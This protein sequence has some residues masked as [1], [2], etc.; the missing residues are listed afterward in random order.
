MV[1]TEGAT[2]VRAERP[3]AGWLILPALGTLIG[4][5]YYAWGVVQIALV[6]KQITTIRADLYIWLSAELMS[7]GLL[8]LGWAGALYL[9]WARHR[10]FPVIFI[11][12]S[13]V[14]AAWL[15]FDYA[16]GTHYFATMDQRDADTDAARATVLATIWI[17]Y[18]LASKRVKATFGLDA[19]AQHGRIALTPEKIALRRKGNRMGIFVS[20]ASAVLLLFG[21]IL[22][23]E[24]KNEFATFVSVLGVLGVL[25]GYVLV[26]TWYWAK[27]S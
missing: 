23:P 5:F 17:P 14:G 15:W 8:T 1:T 13:L 9:L 18:M 27:A 22:S 25:F 2:G 12:L 3:I 6:L 21:F 19:P 7:N 4:P 10:K 16:L 11:A 20:L 26:R 24:G